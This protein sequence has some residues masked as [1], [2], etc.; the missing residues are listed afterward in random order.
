MNAN[1][2]SMVHQSTV[3]IYLMDSILQRSQ[4]WHFTWHS[5]DLTAMWKPRERFPFICTWY[6][7]GQDFNRVSKYSNLCRDSSVSFKP[8]CYFTRAFYASTYAFL[9]KY[10]SLFF[11]SSCEKKSCIVLTF[12]AVPIHITYLYQRISSSI[13]GWL[14]IN[15]KELEVLR[16]MIGHH[17]SHGCWVLTWCARIHWGEEE[18]KIEIDRHKQ[19]M[20]QSSNFDVM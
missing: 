16:W 12:Y 18:E 6:Q 1:S 4:K 7:Y 13:T 5:T 15:L 19:T 11:Q 3:E 10:V 17:N 14:N 8:W 2:I 9:R 20:I